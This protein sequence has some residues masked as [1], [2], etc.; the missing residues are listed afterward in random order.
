[1]ARHARDSYII[2]LLVSLEVDVPENLYIIEDVIYM[3]V[4]LTS[5]SPSNMQLTLHAT[6]PTPHSASRLVQATS[7][8]PAC[9]VPAL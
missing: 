4:R 6:H 7:A 9:S 2:L 1:M 8:N 5:A 3:Q